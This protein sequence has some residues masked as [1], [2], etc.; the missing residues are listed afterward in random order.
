MVEIIQGSNSPIV[1][2]FEDNMSTASKIECSLNN[3][4]TELKHWS[5]DDVVVEE[6]LIS[7]PLYESET[8]NFESG[9]AYLDA[10]ILDV[11]GVIIF[12]NSFKLKVVN[13]FDRTKLTEE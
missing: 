1:L 5:I 11:D 9:T 8:M 7:L 12:Y 6:N 3:G 2:E 4:D 13:K 10:K